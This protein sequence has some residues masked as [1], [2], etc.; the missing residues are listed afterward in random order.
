MLY[1]EM[2]ERKAQRETFSVTFLFQECKIGVGKYSDREKVYLMS[3][4]EKWLH[5]EEE[6]VVQ[7]KGKERKRV[8]SFM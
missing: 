1:V 7:E 2:L 6:T 8:M 4:E 5:I 3:F